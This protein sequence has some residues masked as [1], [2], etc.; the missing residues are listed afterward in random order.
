DEDRRAKIIRRRAIDA[1]IPKDPTSP[2]H[3]QPS[4]SHVQN[5]P[6]ESKP[7]VSKRG[8][9]RPT[10]I[11]TGKPGRPKKAYQ[12]PQ[13]SSESSADPKSTD[14]SETI[15]DQEETSLIHDATTVADALSSNDAREWKKAMMVELNAIEQ[16]K[17]W[18]IVK[19]PIDKNVVGSRWVLQK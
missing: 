2:G 1:T 16:N 17:T 15:T 4:T 13:K 14:S 12:P 18:E 5:Q 9:G 3:H 7:I 19:R 8:R 11:K 6:N 10:T